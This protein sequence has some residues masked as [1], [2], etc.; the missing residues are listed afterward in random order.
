MRS[1][2]RNLSRISDDDLRAMATYFIG[3]NT[4]SG[5]ALEPKIARALT[6]VAP[7]TDKQRAGHKHYMENCASCHGAPGSMPPVARSPLGLSE[8]LWNPYRAYNLVLTVLDGIDGRDGLPGNMPGFRDKFS[9]DDIEALAI[10]L[11]TSHTTM[12]IWGL[13]AERIKISRKDPLP[14]P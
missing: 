3:L 6:P 13:L 7:T 11:R 8:G 4:P 12:P 2:V 1:V 10:Y 9:D 14:L 5:A